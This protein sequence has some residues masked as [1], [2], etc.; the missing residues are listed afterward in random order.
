MQSC[1]IKKHVYKACKCTSL[2]PVEFTFKRNASGVVHP[3]DNSIIHISL[4]EYSPG[5]Q[6]CRKML[7]L[8]TY[9]F[10][11]LVKLHVLRV[12]LHW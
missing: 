12:L 9:S 3:S 2:F 1:L 6:V 8:V 4:M 5:Y 10:W 11:F 7:F